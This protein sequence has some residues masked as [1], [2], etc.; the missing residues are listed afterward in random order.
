MRF[1]WYFEVC[2]LNA[3]SSVLRKVQLIYLCLCLLGFTNG[4]IGTIFFHSSAVRVMTRLFPYTGPP[5]LGAL[6]GPLGRRQ[7][8]STS[9]LGLGR[10][11]LF[12]A[13]R[14]DYVRVRA[15]DCSK[16]KDGLGP[17]NVA[18]CEW[19]DLVQLLLQSSFFFPKSEQNSKSNEDKKI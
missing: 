10:E 4:G 5:A 12:I 1:R 3:S 14:D 8:A 15:R 7:I 9:G 18:I 19:L 17:F 2:H 16:E 11:L 6:W 13:L